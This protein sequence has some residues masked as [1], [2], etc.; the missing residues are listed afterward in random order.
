MPYRLFLP[1]GHDPQRDYPLVLFLHGLSKRGT[2]NISQLSAAG[3]L[4][5]ATQSS[6]FA[7]YLIAP[8][9]RPDHFWWERGSIAL[10]RGILEAL[11]Q[12]EMLAIDWRRVYV[13]G[14]SMGG[15]GIPMLLYAY[16]DLFA[17]GVPV[18]GGVVPKQAA[19]IAAVIKDVPM[20]LFHGALDETVGVE[21]SR[22]LVKGVRA[23][24]GTPRY[25]EYPNEGHGIFSI[26]SADADDA[27]YPWIFDQELA[28]KPMFI[29]G[30]A[31]GDGVVDLEDARAIRDHVLRGNTI[32]PPRD[33]AD[34]NDNEYVT[35]ADA[36]LLES[37]FT[38]G[39]G[40][41][42]PGPFPD[43]GVDPD[44]TT[45][46]FGA[47][48]TGYQIGFSVVSL[49]EQEV[50]IAVTVTTPL[51]ARC[52]N[53][54]F[55][56]KPDVTLT[57]PVFVLAD[58]VVPETLE[59]EQAETLRF[60]SLRNE[61]CDSP[62]VP[63]GANLPLGHL[64]FHHGGSLVACPSGLPFRWAPDAFINVR[65]ARSVIVTGDGEEHHPSAAYEAPCFFVRGDP[66]ADG[67]TDIT[68]AIGVIYYLLGN[69]PLSCLSAADANDDGAVDASDAVFLLT[70]LFVKGGAPPDPFPE[71]GE[72]PRPDELRCTRYAPWR[73]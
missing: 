65:T 37:H 9:E 15:L 7:G 73:Q 57:D 26:V 58:A 60:L 17:A 70:Y 13:V 59:E 25:T 39:A 53:F 54:A 44:N 27:L 51:P 10:V 8:Q 42:I 47:G 33:R 16:P 2:D 29:R 35:L 68:D 69:R 4:I 55:D 14:N 71:V 11:R 31:N 23:A 36:L 20:W 50:E 43:P 5:S 41:V 28:P 24:G 18:S 30:D 6:R 46:T 40:G 34:V 61:G 32:P 22:E 21:F 66:N 12:D 19:A 56:L 64:R 3:N 62:L 38:C 52:V 72:D 1:P 49:T 63:A 48:Q 45:G 67:Y